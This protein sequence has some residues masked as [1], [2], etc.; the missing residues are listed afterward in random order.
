MDALQLVS[1]NRA[2][3][4]KTASARRRRRPQVVL[5][6]RLHVRYVALEK[7]Y[8]EFGVVLSDSNPGFQP[9]GFAGGLYD[10]DTGLVRFGARDYDA[11][12][13]RW[14]TKDPIGFNAGTSNL[15]AYVDSDPLNNVDA[16]GTCREVLAGPSETVVVDDYAPIPGTEKKSEPYSIEKSVCES[17]QAVDSCMLGQW[18]EITFSQSTYNLVLPGV[19]ETWCTGTKTKAN[20]VTSTPIPREE[21]SPENDWHPWLCSVECVCG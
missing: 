10:P 12:V 20:F 16:D 17:G 3:R 8:D 11:E 15:Y 6:D 5:G 13:G 2:R 19:G 1:G 4:R 18:S 9:F 14:T 21:T 7:T